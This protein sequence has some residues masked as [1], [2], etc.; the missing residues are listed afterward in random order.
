MTKRKTSGASK[1]KMSAPLHN[2]RSKSV[3]LS[4]PTDPVK[5]RLTKSAEVPVR[6]RPVAKEQTKTRDEDLPIL[7][8]ERV[9]ERP[10][11]DDQKRVEELPSILETQMRLFESLVR[12]TPL[13]YFMRVQRMVRAGAAPHRL[14][15][16]SPFPFSTTSNA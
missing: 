10:I 14:T 5:R 2:R 12:F 15:S 3:P 9:E 6:R 4:G 7:A 16:L 11:H 8:H 1:K 13:G